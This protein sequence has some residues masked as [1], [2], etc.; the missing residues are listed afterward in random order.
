MTSSDSP[1]PVSVRIPAPVLAGVVSGVLASLA[2]T[3]LNTL[4]D[5][6]GHAILIAA[7]ATPYVAFALVDGTARSIVTE[8][9]VAVAFVAVAFVV[10]DASVWVVAGALAAHGIWDLAHLRT[11][12]TSHVGDYPVWCATLDVSAAAVLVV[13]HLA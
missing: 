12:I 11:H 4:S 2:I 6:Q 10:F 5:T 9:V 1:G 7:V 8:A 13:I 3:L